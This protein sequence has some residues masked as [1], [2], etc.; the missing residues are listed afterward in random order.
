MRDLVD[1]YRAEGFGS[2]EEK[3]EAPIAFPGRETFD[4]STVPVI[5]ADLAF[6][7]LEAAKG[8]PDLSKE[9]EAELIRRAIPALEDW[10]WDRGPSEWEAVEWE[11]VDWEALRILLRH[12]M[13][14]VF[15]AL[16]KW[17][18]DPWYEDLR[19]V[20]IEALLTSFV[21]FDPDRGLRFSTYAKP[22]I[23][24]LVNDAV[25]ML[26]L[27][28]WNR[29]LR[30]FMQAHQ[31]AERAFIAEHRREPWYG[32]LA[33]S[34][35]ALA[36]NEIRAV[37]LSL[38]PEDVGDVGQRLEAIA[39]GDSVHGV[40]RQLADCAANG[41]PR[42][43]EL[44]KKVEALNKAITCLSVLLGS[45]LGARYPIE[46]DAGSEI[47][48]DPEND[49]EPVSGHE[50]LNLSGYTRDR[51]QAATDQ[52]QR[53]ARVRF[54]ASL[55]DSDPRLTPD[56]RN[57]LLGTL[58]LD[59]KGS[60]TPAELAEELGR[61]PDAVV[62]TLKRAAHHIKNRIEAAAGNGERIDADLKG[63]PF[64]PFA[65]IPSA[66]FNPFAEDRYRAE[67]GSV[68]IFSDPFHEN[69]ARSA[70]YLERLSL[71]D[72][73]APW[74]AWDKAVRE[75]IQWARAE[76][77]AFEPSLSSGVNPITGERCKSAPNIRSG[78]PP[79]NP[80]ERWRRAQNF[81][82]LRL[83]VVSVPGRERTGDFDDEFITL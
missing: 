56:Q 23:R 43:P 48:G 10:E 67:D 83:R 1:L 31:T 80:H 44:A 28:I 27:G 51:E 39:E 6:F 52:G 59:G 42:S 5:G 14:L 32:E 79:F 26:G 22:R 63:E 37:W 36:P 58:G 33:T 8:L 20:G 61:R 82:P 65:G 54:I 75:S 18:D 25:E 24:A 4:I 53:E 11:A 76:G 12:H 57:A 72:T 15:D 71:P 13:K 21:G 2:L 30:G 62:L 7:D 9:E 69:P 34:L 49:S 29:E 77:K 60:R 45:A 16:Y 55:I 50:L 3:A 74:G 66:F 41:E 47:G 78:P 70:G 38:W 64:D 19:Q 68:G 81:S 46:L 73:V 17:R 40:V 35:A